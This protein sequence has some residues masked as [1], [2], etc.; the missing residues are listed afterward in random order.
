MYKRD[1]VSQGTKVEVDGRRSVVGGHALLDTDAKGQTGYDRMG[2]GKFWVGEGGCDS[3]G[4]AS[5]HRRGHQ[6]RV[7]SSLTRQECC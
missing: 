6:E 3:L 7:G 4:V 5:L 2:E 1:I